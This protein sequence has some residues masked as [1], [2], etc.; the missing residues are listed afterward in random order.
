MVSQFVCLL[1]LPLFGSNATKAHRSH[2]STGQNQ[3]PG[4]VFKGKKMAGHM[5]NKNVT[6][7]NLRVIKIDTENQ[8]LYVIGAVPGPK[9]GLIEVS[10]AIFK[11]HARPPPFP[12]FI[13][14]EK[15][16]IP[17]FLYW[18]FADPF[19]KVREVDWEIK[20]LEALAALKAAQASGE[21]DVDD[22][23]TSGIK[24]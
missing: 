6:V 16:N 18:R 11:P 12:T 23:A 7:H 8:M 17:R 24:L 3:D 22:S 2:G 4:R 13:R 5:G 21:S 19:K 9:G 1:H 20:S 14:H 15:A 10:D